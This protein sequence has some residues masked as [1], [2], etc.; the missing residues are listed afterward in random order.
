MTGSPLAPIV[1]TTGS[2]PTILPITVV[3]N[4]TSGRSST[5]LSTGSFSVQGV[6]TTHASTDPIVVDTAQLITTTQVSYVYAPGGA[7]LPVASNYSL[8]ETPQSTGSGNISSNSKATS[9]GTRIESPTNMSTTAPVYTG[10][11]FR[12]LK[13]PNPGALCLLG[14]LVAF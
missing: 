2:S 4:A 6:T 11:A 1:V 5:L 7:S 3:S 12:A 10:K 8:V 13:E 14:M 9:L